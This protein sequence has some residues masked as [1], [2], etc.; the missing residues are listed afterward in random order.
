[1]TRVDPDACEVCGR[2]ADL[3]I[4]WRRFLCERC[5]GRHD[6]IAIDPQHADVVDD[7]GHRMLRL[8]RCPICETRL[9]GN[10][11]GPADGERSAR[12]RAVASHVGTHNPEDLGLSPIE[13]RDYQQTLAGLGGGT[14]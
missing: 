13:T 11:G 2:E 6:G 1:M 3:R 9:N 14:A 10:R 4:V 12:A 8:L 7:G 5:I